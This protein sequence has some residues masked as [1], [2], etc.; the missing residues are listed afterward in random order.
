MLI[1]LDGVVPT[2]T[3][4]VSASCYPPSTIKSRKLSCGTGS[5]GLSQ[6]KGRITVVVVVN[7]W[8]L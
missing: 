2:Q 5:P 1:G 6:K 4:D 7:V 3:V 8:F